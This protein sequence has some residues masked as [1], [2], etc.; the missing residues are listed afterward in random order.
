[1]SGELL[2]LLQAQSGKTQIFMG[3]ATLE[4]STQVRLLEDLGDATL[5][6]VTFQFKGRTGS[7]A[8][9]LRFT[10]PVGESEL[11]QFVDGDG[12][13]LKPSSSGTAKLTLK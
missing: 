12:K 13:E 6:A 7:A 10:V 5:P 4:R 3:I 9:D 2:I 11:F 1:M 8:G